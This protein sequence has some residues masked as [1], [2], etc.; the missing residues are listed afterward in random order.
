MAVRCLAVIIRG[1][2]YFAARLLAVVM[3]AMEKRVKQSTED[4]QECPGKKKCIV[5]FYSF[6]TV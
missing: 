5:N 6:H 2:N 3:P 4:I 1:N